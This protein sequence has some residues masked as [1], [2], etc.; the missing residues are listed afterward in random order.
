MALLFYIILGCVVVG[1]VLLGLVK[2][3]LEWL[4]K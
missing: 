3:Q 1:C 4:Y 2:T